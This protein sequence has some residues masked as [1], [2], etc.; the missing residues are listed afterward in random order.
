[1][2]AEGLNGQ[3]GAVIDGVPTRV[4]QVLEDA[5]SIAISMAVLT[6]HLCDCLFLN[7]R[8]LLTCQGPHHFWLALLHLQ[9]YGEQKS[10]WYNATAQV[11]SNSP[12]IYWD[13]VPCLR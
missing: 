3:E 6:H 10:Y 8:E 1:M 9:P 5:A 4:P 13:K 12:P 7:S 11:T 2:A